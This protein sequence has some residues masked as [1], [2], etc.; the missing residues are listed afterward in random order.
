MI[1][2]T[3]A[4]GHFGNATINFL[5]EKGMQ[6]DQIIAMV[7][8]SNAAEQFVQRGLR[9]AIADYNSYHSLVTAFEGVDQLLFISGSDILNRAAQHHNVVMAAEEAGVKHVIYSSFQRKN[10]SENSPLWIVAQSHLQTEQWLRESKMDC[11]ILRNNL[12]MDFVPAFIG[13]KV[14]EQGF[15]YIPA[16]D[17]KVSAVLR[18]EMAEAT[19]NI[20]LSQGHESKTYFF[21]NAESVSYHEVARILSGIA[22]NPVNYISP[23]PEEY[24]ETMEKL[25][26]PQHVVGLFASFAIAQAAGELEQPSNDLTR[27]LGRNPTS[28]NDYLHQVYAVKH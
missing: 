22:K 10:E 12:Y 21:S 18:A 5:L 2:V 14:L 11:T 15:I 13:E 3:G 26:V 19:A 1:L 23:T 9:V 16:E 4:T 27:L 17:G 6:A 8:N 7:R 28:L 25:G 24:A 20:L